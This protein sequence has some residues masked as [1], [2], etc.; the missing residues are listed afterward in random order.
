MVIVIITLA[1]IIKMMM[2]MIIITIIGLIVMNLSI[3]QHNGCFI[4]YR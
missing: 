4:N 2:L 3:L 1:I